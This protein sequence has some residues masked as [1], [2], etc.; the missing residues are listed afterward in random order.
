M[1]IYK[2][3]NYARVA[4]TGLPYTALVLQCKKM[5]HVYVYC[6]ENNPSLVFLGLKN[7]DS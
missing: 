4:L 2:I 7:Q 6:T 3:E 5:E 1:Y